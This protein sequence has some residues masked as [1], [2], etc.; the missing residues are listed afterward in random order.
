MYL[1][2]DQLT[3][4]LSFNSDETKGTI[5][6]TESSTGSGIFN[7]MII[8]KYLKD[9]YYRYELIDTT[10]YTSPYTLKYNADNQMIQLGSQNKYMAGNYNPNYYGSNR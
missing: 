1:R 7:L 8:D 5:F 3:N 10:S 9:N 4:R 2:Y 6:Q